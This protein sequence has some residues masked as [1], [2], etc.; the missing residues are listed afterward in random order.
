MTEKRLVWE[1]EDNESV[2]C[3]N[4]EKIYLGFLRY[5]KVGA[6]MHWCWYQFDHIRM[7]PGCL[8]EV[9]EKQK[10]LFKKVRK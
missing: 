5:E 3:Y 6:H 2:S 8:E 7:S 10:E 4:K 1:D 9:R